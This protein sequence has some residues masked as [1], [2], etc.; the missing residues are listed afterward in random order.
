MMAVFYYRSLLLVAGVNS[1][2]FVRD[3]VQL[4]D[5]LRPTQCGIDFGVV[6]SGL[7]AGKF[8]RVSI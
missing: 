6:S 8:K 7:D 2:E 1:S 3:F 4:Q 5:C